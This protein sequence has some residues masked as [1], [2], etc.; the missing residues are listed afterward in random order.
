M[1]D[2]YKLLDCLMLHNQPTLIV[3]LFLNVHFVI[4]K[5]E[6]LRIKLIAGVFL[7]SCSR[8]NQY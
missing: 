1:T 4:A 3:F 7:T 6:C 5:H 8:T 2:L